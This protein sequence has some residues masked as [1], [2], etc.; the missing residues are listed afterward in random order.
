MIEYV[1]TCATIYIAR[2]EVGGIMKKLFLIIV[3]F[4]VG[5][6]TTVGGV[7]VSDQVP[8]MSIDDLKH[9]LG[10][11]DTVILDVRTGWSWSASND[12]IAGAIREDPKQFSHWYDK[13]P[14]DKTLVL[15]C[16]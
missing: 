7:P 9:R 2:E 16:S 8:R 4:L 15:Y 12:K 5:G 14:K 3:I 6:C 13:Y 1:K 10:S 11:S